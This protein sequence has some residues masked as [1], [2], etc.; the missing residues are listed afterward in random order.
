MADGLSDGRRVRSFDGV[1]A[2]ANLQAFRRGRQAVAA[3]ADFAAAVD[4]RRAE[5]TAECEPLSD[6]ARDL[7]AGVDAPPVP[8][9]PASSRYE[10]P[11]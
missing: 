7:I 6:E 10:S 9:W 1:K 8:S 5:R 3:P 11:T 2:E 4:E